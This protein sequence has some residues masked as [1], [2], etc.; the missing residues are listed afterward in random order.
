[1]ILIITAV[2]DEDV[3]TLIARKLIT[4]HLA[5]CV[6]LLPPGKSFYRWDAKIEE[7][8]EHALHIK[9]ADD[10]FD[11]V[12]AA[13]KAMHPYDVPMILKLDVAAANP[14]FLDWVENETR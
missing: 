1:M 12:V 13:I 3:G 8:G 7:A 4:D 11:R 10:K 6:H 14:E 2:P 9:T 5:A